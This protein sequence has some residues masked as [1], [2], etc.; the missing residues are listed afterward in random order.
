M[1]ESSEVTAAK[2]LSTPFIVPKSW[3]P[4]YSKKAI[5]STVSLA[6]WTP[7]RARIWAIF[8]GSAVKNLPFAAS[9]LMSGLK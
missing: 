7:G 2:Y 1:V 9:I 8:A 3:L 4:S 6:N 5:S